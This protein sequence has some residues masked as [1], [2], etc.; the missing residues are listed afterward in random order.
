LPLCLSFVQNGIENPS[1]LFIVIPIPMFYRERPERSGAS[2]EN[3]SWFCWNSGLLENWNDGFLGK[4]GR[5]CEA[6]QL[7]RRFSPGVEN[8]IFLFMGFSRMLFL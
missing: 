1:P 8:G 7:P 2:L 4:C 5:G 3:L 6:I